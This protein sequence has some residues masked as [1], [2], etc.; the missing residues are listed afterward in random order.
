MYSTL[1]TLQ[2]GEG[3][4]LTNLLSLGPTTNIDI[5][6]FHQGACLIMGFGHCFRILH[7]AARCS[8]CLQP[9]TPP[10]VKPKS[11]DVKTNCGNGLNTPRLG[12]MASCYM[13]LITGSSFRRPS[14][15]AIICF[16]CHG[17]PEVR[18]PSCQEHQ[19]KE[20]PSCWTTRFCS[21]G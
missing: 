11:A 8:K 10:G 14:Q 4:C 13:R 3:D 21:V 16:R 9:V 12:S 2:L 20:A 17:F 15:S 5:Q 6:R 19:K 7:A 18:A 1:A